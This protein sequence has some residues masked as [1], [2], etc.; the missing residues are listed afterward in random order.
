ME[1][2][3]KASGGPLTPGLLLPT[4]I[5]SVLARRI[6]DALGVERPRDPQKPR[7]LRGHREDADHDRC[8][9]RVHLAHDM[10]LLRAGLDDDVRVPQH[11][12]ARDVPLLGLRPQGVPRLR[13]HL[14]PVV[15][16]G[17]RAGLEHEDVH[18]G[19][20]R[21]FLAG[22][23]EEHA[24][25]LVEDFGQ[26]R[27]SV[28]AVSADAVD[29]QRDQDVERLR[30]GLGGGDEPV[31][32]AVEPLGARDAVVDIDVLGSGGPAAL[33]DEGAGTFDTP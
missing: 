17:E 26:L 21:H 18:R 24:D 30:P 6:R 11:L 33:L 27:N 7:S 2:I 15:R 5:D 23:V 10:R 14:M 25:A 4:P 13:S 22:L 28:N 19:L 31:Q 16:G 12:P 9:V 29:V 3:P 8:L 32:L 20:D 1:D